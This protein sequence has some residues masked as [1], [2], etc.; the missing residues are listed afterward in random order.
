MAQPLEDYQKGIQKDPMFEE[1][2]V[3]LFKEGN[4]FCL[5][6]KLGAQ[7][8]TKDGIE[9]THF[10]LWAPNAKEVSVIGNFN[11]WDKEAHRLFP[12]WDSSGIWEGFIPG[13]K[14]GHR[15]KYHILS[16]DNNHRVDKK[17]PFAFYG[18]IP[19]LSGSIVWDLDYEWSDADWMKSRQQHNNFNA[20]ISIYEIH[21]GSWRQKLNDGDRFLS[22]R[23]LAPYLVDY[24]KAMGFTHVEFMPVM[25]HPFYGSWGYQSVGYFSPSS[26]FGTPQDFM[27]LIDQLHQ[28]GIG[29]ILDWVPSHFPTDELGLA[30][31]DGTHLYEHADPRKGFHPDW[32]SYI[33]N[34]G[35]NEV[36]EFLISSALFW[37][38][39]YHV[40]GL[41]VDAV[42]S[43]L[44]L[45]YSRKSG[46]WAPNEQ[47]GRDNLEAISFMKRLNEVVYTHYPSVQMIAEESS[48]WSMVSRPVYNGGLGFGMK[49][50]M[51]WMHDTLEYFHKDPVHRKY[52]HNDLT[53]SMLYA[54]RE[55]FILALSHD[56]VVHGKGSLLAKMPCDDWQKFANLRLLYG[57]MFSHPGKKLL[58]M[59]GEF[60]QWNEWYHETSLDWHLLQ[61]SLH[62]GVQNLVK[63]LNF[64]YKN[65]AALHEL[66]FSEAGF[67]WIDC[68]DWQ[69]GIVSFIRKGKSTD[70]KI[71]VVC[72]LTPAVRHDYH[73]GVPQRG[74]WKEILNTDSSF[75]GGSNLGNRGGLEAEPFPF[76]GRPFSLKLT[77][78][79][80]CA[81]YFKLYRTS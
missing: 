80:L 34:H 65:E 12:R 36:R 72:N 38:D 23:E 29:V 8:L 74:F 4:H 18:E 37:L 78:P 81:V 60:G 47:G 20:P 13:V 35:R 30:Y 22:Y 45:D 58:F 14:K 5:Y 40:D 70:E 76:H 3:Y 56:E 26:R 31:F 10:A 15:Y 54:F 79:S 43:M 21:V 67:E 55:N 19:P 41:R 50:N 32:S 17:D 51:G 39:K 53:F 69:Q 46:E 6:E 75:Y 9:G 49:W 27:Y 64:L 77:L 28:N 73:I 62:Q 63:D 66:D 71:V 2:D 24:L 52:H 25:E 16:N 59:G 7:R 68:S 42:A 57:Y 61:Y 44:Y 48:S 11:N 33:F 1:Q